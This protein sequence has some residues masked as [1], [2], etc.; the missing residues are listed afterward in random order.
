MKT[1]SRFDYFQSE[2]AVSVLP[3][4]PQPEFP[5]HGHDFHELVLIRSGC[6]L[7]YIDG[8]P[9]LADKGSVFHIGVGQAHY[10]D[11]IE[12]LNLTN[13]VFSPERLQSLSLLGFLPGNRGHQKLRIKPGTLSECESLCAA[14]SH[15]CQRQDACSGS[16]V[17]SLFAQLVVRWWREENSLLQ[18]QS[19][20]KTV[21]LIYFLD[22]NFATEIDFGELADRF[23][24]PLRTLNRHLLN[25]TGLTP[26]NYLT[27]VRL[28][29]AMR[30][31]WQSDL[32]ITDIA[33]LCGFND[34]NYFSSRFH[35]EI[36]L[37]P[38]QFRARRRGNLDA[39]ATFHAELALEAR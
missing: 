1:L 20:D 14:I 25:V 6:A 34:S 10:F 32:P 39:S 12:N 21:S 19:E 28:C 9:F 24:I 16:M 8:T 37:S 35:R 13:I 5:E 36:G 31:L 4:T 7:H 23:C 27:R 30:M 22:Q 33:Y 15:E 29:N 18:Q 38:K 2:M 26:N 11:H 3:R 17:E